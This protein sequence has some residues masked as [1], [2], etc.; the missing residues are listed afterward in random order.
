MCFEEKI[1]AYVG[2]HP[3]VSVSSG[4]AAVHVALLV[5]G[6]R[7]RDDVIMPTLTFVAPANAIRY[8]GA[9]PVLVDAE[10]EFRQMDVDRAKA[11]VLRQYARTNR[12]WRHRRTG[13]RLSAIL[14][15]D[16]LGHPCDIDRVLEL[17]DALGVAVVDDAAEAFGATVNG[18]V[19]GGVAPVSALS[20]NANK[21]MTTGGGG[22]VVCQDELAARRARS[23]A[24]HCK[25]QPPEEE[26]ERRVHP[27]DHDDVGMNY[28]MPTIHAAL[29]L[30]QFERLESFIT[31]KRR[32]AELY[33]AAFES[34][35]DVTTPGEA[36]WAR[37]TFWLYTVHVDPSRR[38]ALMDD[39]KADG[40][41]TRPMFLPMHQVKAHER[42]LADACPV[43]EELAASGISLPCSTSITD[44]QVRFVIERVSDELGP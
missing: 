33:N 16:L 34:R 23:L 35:T 36:G 31:R 10:R 24:S 2:G 28:L 29:G 12:E 20:F 15:I 3:V 9:H 7:A 41:E 5:A 8:I 37:A 11:F 21:I 44:A 39:L 25:S 42:E 22:M 17:G 6:V 27:Y 43:A 38:E 1:S 18:R 4:T 40:I 13:R 32:V 30:E 19:A 14:A 26:P